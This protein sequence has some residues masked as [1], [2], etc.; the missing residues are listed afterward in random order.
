MATINDPTTFIIA[1]LTIICCVGAFRIYWKAKNTDAIMWV[2]V[3][4]FWCVDALSKAI[5]I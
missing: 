3:T 2:L 1:G 5:Q 4:F